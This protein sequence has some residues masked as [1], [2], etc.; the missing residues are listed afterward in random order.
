[1]RVTV[2]PPQDLDRTLQLCRQMLVCNMTTGQTPRE[3]HPEK[4][5][6]EMGRI[7]SECFLSCVMVP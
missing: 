5:Q 3:D 1:M 4:A 2:I 6:D 7:T